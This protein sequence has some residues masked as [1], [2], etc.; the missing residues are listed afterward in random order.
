MAHLP[1]ATNQQSATDYIGPVLYEDR[2]AANRAARVDPHSTELLAREKT[3]IQNWRRAMNAGSATREI[4]KTL[5][6]LALSGGGI[7]SATFALGVTQAFAAQDLMRRFDYLSTVSG[8]GYLG[9]SLTWLTRNSN[10]QDADRRF[11]F[12]M[13]RDHFP[14][15]VDPPD[16]QTNRRTDPAQDAQLIYLRQHGKYLTPGRGIDIVSAIAVVLRGVLLNL[17]V[18]LPLA[19]L[20]L[21][22]LLLVPSVDTV[23]PFVALRDRIPNGYGWVAI[24]SAVTALAFAV[25]AVIYSLMTYRTRVEHARHLIACFIYSLKTYNIHNRKTY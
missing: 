19:A 1:T 4:D 7:R 17:L 23:L 3:Y 14:Y 21:L 25:L 11:T 8:G 24:V 13:D 18:W 12:G 9:S 16:R 5:A 20:V 22:L 10:A 15:P 6:G 2:I